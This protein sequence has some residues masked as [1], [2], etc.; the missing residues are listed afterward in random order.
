VK[1]HNGGASWRTTGAQ[2]ALRATACA[3]RPFCSLL[4]DCVEFESSTSVRK[5][6]RAKRPRVNPL[7]AVG[8]RTDRADCYARF[9]LHREFARGTYNFGAACL[10]SRRAAAVS[11]ISSRARERV[12]ASERAD[13]RSSK[14][15][16]AN[17]V[18]VADR[19]PN[20]RTRI[21]E[22]SNTFDAPFA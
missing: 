15:I 12:R 13:E 22:L 6:H 19:S 2:N 1:R 20:K 10:A 8:R 11:R 16:K 4:E 9:V 14:A 17:K 18:P 21:D 5:H 3:S 7:D